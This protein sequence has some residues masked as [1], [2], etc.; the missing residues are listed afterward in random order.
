MTIKIGFI[1]VGGIAQ[2][3]MDQLEKF[4]NVKIVNVYDVNQ[5]A[6]KQVA[7]SVGAQVVDR[8]ETLLNPNEIDAVYICTPQFARGEL[9][10][11]A[12]RRGIPF[13]VEKPLGVN[14]DE[15]RSKA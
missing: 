3:H 5:E 9:E 11:E 14:L 12:A 2:S 8:P 7:E 6:A 4:P 15:V 1:G 10:V 13:F